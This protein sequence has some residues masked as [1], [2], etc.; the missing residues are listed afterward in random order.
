[1]NARFTIKQKL[2]L[3]FGLLIPSEVART[4][5]AITA[6]KARPSLSLMVKRMAVPINSGSVG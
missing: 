2:G 5:S 6:P 1:M 4:S 3:A